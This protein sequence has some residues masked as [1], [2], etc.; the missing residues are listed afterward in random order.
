MV[1]PARCC[2]IL[3]EAIGRRLPAIVGHDLVRVHVRSWLVVR[4]VFYY[5]DVYLFLVTLQHFSRRERLIA[6]A[7]VVVVVN[8]IAAMNLAATFLPFV[9]VAILSL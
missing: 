9:S 6:Y 4:Y 1:L 7:S 8:Q 3:E 2:K 5:F